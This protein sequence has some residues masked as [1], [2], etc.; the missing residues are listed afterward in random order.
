MYD[1][2]LFSFN[3]GSFVSVNVTKNNPYYIYS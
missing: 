2:M 3:M 1:E